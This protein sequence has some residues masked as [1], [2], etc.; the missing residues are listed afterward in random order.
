M[1]LSALSIVHG[2]SS[3]AAVLSDD[4]HTR[5]FVFFYTCSVLSAIHALRHA[6]YMVSEVLIYV[7]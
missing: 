2:R 5:H 7:P 6:A 1:R 4:W 3:E